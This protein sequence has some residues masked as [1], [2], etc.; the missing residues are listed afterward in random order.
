[1]LVT[2][3]IIWNMLVNYFMLKIPFKV[4]VN[5]FKVDVAVK[6]VLLLR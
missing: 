2:R 4:L 6:C 3:R 1:M 5:D